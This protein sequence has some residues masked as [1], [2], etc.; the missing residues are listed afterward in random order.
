MMMNAM[1]SLN[2]QPVTRVKAGRVRRRRVGEAVLDYVLLLAA[3]LPMLAI[4]YY[5]S[6]RIIRAVYEMT[7]TLICWPFM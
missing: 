1:K 6:M 7:C 2:R 3:V 5:Y 4:S